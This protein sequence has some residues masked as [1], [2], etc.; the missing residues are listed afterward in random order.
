MALHS[1]PA[2]TSN[3]RSDVSA[4][5]E[6]MPPTAAHEESAA[7]PTTTIGPIS[8]AKHPTGLWS[9]GSPGGLAQLSYV[10]LPECFCEIGRRDNGRKVIPMTVTILT[11]QGTGVDMWTGFPAQVAWRHR[12]PTPPCSTGSP[13]ET[14]PLQR[15]RWDPA[16]LPAL[17]RVSGC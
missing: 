14:G 1:T 12:T 3:D 8:L 16:S 13:L 11:W 2:R 17:R 15:I 5:A 6:P 7:A 9:R 4:R 10:S